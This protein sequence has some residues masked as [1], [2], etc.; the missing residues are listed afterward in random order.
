MHIFKNQVIPVGIHNISKSGK[1]NLDTIQVLL[2]GKKFIPK[3]DKK[4][5][6]V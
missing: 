3:W 5:T 1:P 6:Y 4:N 2:L